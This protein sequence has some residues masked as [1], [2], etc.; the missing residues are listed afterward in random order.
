MI[1]DYK[2]KSRSV[3]VMFSPVDM[4]YLQSCA[5]ECGLRLAE[6]V[7]RAAMNQ[8]TTALLSQDERNAVAEL[9]NIGNNLNQVTRAM[10]LGSD[11]RSDIQDIVKYIT[12]ILRKLK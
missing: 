10:H 1:P 5:N 7:H 9:R 3:K 12:G 4:I 2:K 8:K 6:Y 11:I